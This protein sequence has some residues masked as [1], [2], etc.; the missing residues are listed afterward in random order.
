MINHWLICNL[1]VKLNTSV[2]N[3]ILISSFQK[4]VEKYHRNP[5]R[6][7]NEDIAEL[8]FL[9]SE[10]KIQ[11]TYHTEGTKISASTREFI[12][13]PNADEK[14]TQLVMTPDMHLTFQV[15]VYT[16]Y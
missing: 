16:L 13:P 1:E 4:M 12:K 14:G 6:P 5:K 3:V 7:A 9:I 10:E 2:S 15:K 8:L 11:I